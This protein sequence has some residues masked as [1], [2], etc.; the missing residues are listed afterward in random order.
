MEDHN[1]W[2]RAVLKC[3]AEAGLRLKKQKSLF[4]AVQVEFLRFRVDKDGIKP[5]CEKVEAIKKAPPPRNKS[6]LQ[7][8]LG[9]LNFYSCFL[10][11]KVT[12]LEPLHRL[13]DQSAT[14]QWGAKH[15][16]AYVQAKQ[17][18]QTDKVLAHYNEKKPL[19]V[20]CDASPYGLGDLL[21]HL[22]CDGQEKPI[23]F[24]S[25][26]MTCDRAD[27]LSRLPLS[28]SDVVTPPPLEVLLLEMEPD[29]PMHTERI[30]NLTLKDPVMSRALRWVLHGWPAEIPDS[31][32]RPFILRHH[33][34]C[35]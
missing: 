6:E 21:F 33:E 26:T 4:E 22:E 13:L 34:L 10:P 23:C 31:R 12:V 3:L 32:F 27:A 30:S 35:A 5:T 9:L 18:L 14:W 2:L 17:L 16:S 29:A 15:E 8:F 1:T 20:V 19:A 25:R 11:N 28:A 7:A 24:A